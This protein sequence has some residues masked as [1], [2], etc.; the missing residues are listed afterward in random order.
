[1][2]DGWSQPTVARVP[3]SVRA[4]G[5]LQPERGQSAHESGASDARLAPHISAI[6]LQDA[7]AC[8][9]AVAGQWGSFRVYPVNSWNE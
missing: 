9:G 3:E 5:A 1:M 7:T 6:A 2:L 4:E 8:S